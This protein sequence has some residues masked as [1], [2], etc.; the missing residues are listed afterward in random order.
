[1]KVVILA[2]G[3][4]SRLSQYTQSIPKPMIRIRSK[5]IIQHIIDIY[6]AYGFKE[7]IIAAGYKYK[8]IEKYIKNKKN[9]NLN[10]KVINTGLNTL[11]SLRIKKLEKYLN[12]ETFLITMVRWQI[13]ILVNY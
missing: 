11:T 9:Y 8:I 3:K 1:M 5:P 13:L 7:I 12:N 6:S 4:G 2:G 10:V